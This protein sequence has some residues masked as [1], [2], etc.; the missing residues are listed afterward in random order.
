MQQWPLL[1]THALEYAAQWH[2]DQEIVCRTVEGPI[3]ISTYGDLS[4]RAKLCALAL[5]HLGVK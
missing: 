4:R 5:A 3:N 1:V 2:K